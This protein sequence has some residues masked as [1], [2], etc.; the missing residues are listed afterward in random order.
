MSR[1]REVD[2]RGDLPRRLGTDA[3]NG[4]EVENRTERDRSSALRDAASEC[5][6]DVR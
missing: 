2:V 5:G 6:T 4:L 3:G 1:S